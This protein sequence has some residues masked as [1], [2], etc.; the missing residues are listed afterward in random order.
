MALKFNSCWTNVGTISE[1]IL[2]TKIGLKREPKMEP[3]VGQRDQA[4][5]ELEWLEEGR[6]NVLGL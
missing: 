2:E 4:W 6:R 5:L 1:S 3:K